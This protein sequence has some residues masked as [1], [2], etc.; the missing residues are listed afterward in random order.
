MDVAVAADPDHYEAVIKGNE[1]AHAA[2]GHWGVPTFVFENEPFFEAKREEP[3]HGID[4]EA[5][6]QAFAAHRGDLRA[7]GLQRR[8]DRRHIG[9]AAAGTQRRRDRHHIGDDR[10]ADVG[11]RPR[12]PGL[13]FRRQRHDRGPPDHD[14][15]MP[16]P[17][18][19]PQQRTRI[20]PRRQVHRALALGFHARGVQVGHR[21]ADAVLDPVQRIVVETAG[22][23]GEQFGERRREQ[24]QQLRRIDPD[25]ADRARRQHKERDHEAG[26]RADRDFEDSVDRGVQRVGVMHRRQQQY[27]H[28]RHRR[29]VQ[30]RIERGDE[31]QRH[32]RQHQQRQQTALAGMR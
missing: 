31:G 20:R 13:D 24:F 4:R 27:D 22:Q 25:L 3:L 21:R 1:D 29:R 32:D 7:I 10:L 11:E 16:Q 8:I 12:Q 9:R 18:D 6:R 15:V 19:G 23:A 26:E 2:S 14:D 28:R 30:A 17:L 5:P